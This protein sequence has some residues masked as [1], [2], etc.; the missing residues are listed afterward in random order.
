MSHCGVCS[1]SF[2]GNTAEEII[3][4]AKEAGLDGIEW[5]SDVHVRPDDRENAVTVRRKMD[6][7][8][9]QTLSYGTYFGIEQL[10]IE[11][12]EAYLKTAD[13]LGTDVLRIWPPNS[14]ISELSRE[15]Y[16]RYVDFARQVA[17]CAQKYGK[18]L[19]L[20]RHPNTMT[21][22]PTD[23]LRYLRD[24]GKENVR[25]YWQPNQFADEAE[26]LESAALL[27]EW[28]EH[29]H[30]FEWH[31]EQRYPLRDG[32]ERWCR[33]AGVIGQRERAW[34]LEFMPDDR[35]T[36]LRPSAETLREI[37]ET[38]RAKEERICR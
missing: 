13:I 16:E 2:R 18:R 31:G 14:G 32:L 28:I 38:A 37:L 7:A 27:S 12:I 29:V 17:V 3:R 4:A 8:G 33:Y 20:E 15:A 26:N 5:G 35:I 36:S 24:I 25:M 23:A 30:V 34:L 9:L 10:E 21:E 19:C 22:K 1:V 6:E 11:P